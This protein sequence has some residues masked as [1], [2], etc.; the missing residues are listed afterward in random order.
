M[1]AVPQEE[2][3]AT[4][5]L[6][7]VN[8][9]HSLHCYR[10]PGY[11]EIPQRVEKILAELR[12]TGMFCEVPGRGFPEKH[13]RAVHGGDFLTYLRR[14]CAEVPEGAFV[15][16][17]TFPVGGMARPP[18]SLLLKAGCY[19]LDSF[20]PL[21]PGCY[22][23]ARRA[24][25]CTLTAA[26]AV[27]R[28]RRIAYALVRPPG[29]HAE[30][31]CFGGYCYLNNTAVAA[32]YLS[33]RGKVA[34]VDLDYHHG[35]GQQDIFY[36]RDD[37]LTISLHGHPDVAFPYFSGYVDELGAGPGE[38]FNLNF[39]LPASVGGRQYRRALSKALRVVA[40]FRPAFLVVALG[41]DTAKGDPCGSWSLGSEDFS[42]NGQ[43]LGRLRLPTLVVQEGGYRLRT[44]GAHARCFFEG[45]LHGIG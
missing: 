45:L 5:I 20:T 42:A 39:P 23:A 11:T 13:L 36:R 14:A 7:V 43:L 1:V 21:G 33:H 29:H 44:L 16:A 4:P 34:I 3:G 8:E 2:S 32:H 6:L 15:C 31:H 35:N 37:V 41:L 28:G 19:C 10:E 22:A 25:D 17:D 12:P 9:H 27:L 18:R 38:G 40:D 26:D 24:V 30:R